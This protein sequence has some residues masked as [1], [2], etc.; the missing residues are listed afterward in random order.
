MSRLWVR[1]SNCSRES[2][3]MNGDR[4]TRELLDPGRQR[5]RADDVR[6][7]ALRRLHDLGCRLVEQPVVVGLEADRIRCFA[8][9]AYSVM[10]VMTPAP[11]VRPPSRMAKRR[12]S[13]S[14]IGV[15]SSTFISTLSPGITISTPSG[16][17]IAPVT[18][19]VRM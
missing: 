8:I 1:I 5:H 11:T 7:R 15:I 9:V 6:A 12:P 19:V 16:S 14:A 18:S 3:S 13:S 2:L 4:R 17:P 10:L